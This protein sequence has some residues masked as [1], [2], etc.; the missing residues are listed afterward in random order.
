M[1]TTPTSNLWVKCFNPDSEAN[2]RLFCFPYAGGSALDFRNWS[3]Q[4]PTAIEICSIELPERG[5]RMQEKPFT[6]MTPLVEAIAL[7]LLISINPLL[8]SVTA[9]AG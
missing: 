6:R 7:A 5:R 1:I 2:L 3:D 8:F 9:W 4:L